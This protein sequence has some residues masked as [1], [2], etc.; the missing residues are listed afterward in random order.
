MRDGAPP[1]SDEDLLVEWQEY[2]SSLLNNVNGQTPSDL[3]Q[4][5]AQDLPIYDHPLTLEETLEAIRQVKTNKAAG[6]DCV[7]TTE[8]LQGGGDAMADVIHWPVDHQGGDDAMADV[9]HWP[10]GGSFNIFGSIDAN[11]VSKYALLMSS[12]SS[13]ME[14]TMWQIIWKL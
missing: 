14:C 4:P 13:V 11:E 7:I 2:F 8:A 6:P 5:A 9:I 3:A 10:V 1:K 12:L